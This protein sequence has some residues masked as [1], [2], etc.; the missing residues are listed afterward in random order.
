M[1]GDT[2]EILKWPAHNDI[3]SEVSPQS[4]GISEVSMAEQGVLGRPLLEGYKE[5]KKDWPFTPAQK[6]GLD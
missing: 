6:K 2:R 4:A 3:I 5:Q 1:Y